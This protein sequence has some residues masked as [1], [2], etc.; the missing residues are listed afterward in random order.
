M[1]KSAERTPFVVKTDHAS[2]EWLRSWE[3]ASSRVRRWLTQLQEFT[4]DAEYK[5][6]K[7]NQV[8]DA[9]SRIEHKLLTAPLLKSRTQPTEFPG[10]QPTDLLDFPPEILWSQAY[11]EDGTYGPY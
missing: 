1:G 7:Q 11:E 2:L 5:P 10:L 6:G 3:N 4:F 9:L 8:A